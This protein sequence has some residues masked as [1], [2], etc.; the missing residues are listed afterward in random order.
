MIIYSFKK[1]ISTNQTEQF[2]ITKKR[3][4]RL[5]VTVVKKTLQIKKEI[6]K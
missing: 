1:K 3:K 4:K 5:I 6:G 2:S